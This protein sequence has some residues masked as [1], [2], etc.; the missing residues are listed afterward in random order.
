M[1]TITGS[2]RARRLR[3][4]LTI[5][6]VAVAAAAVAALGAATIPVFRKVGCSAMRAQ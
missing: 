4:G 2:I 3:R 6:E 1:R 5:T